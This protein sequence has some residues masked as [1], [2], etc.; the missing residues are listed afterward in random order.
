MKMSESIKNQPEKP[1]KSQRKKEVHDLQKIGETLVSLSNSLLAQI[2]LPNYLLESIYHAQTLKSHEAIRRQLQYIGKLMREVDI[3]PI[4]AALKKIQFRHQEDAAQ[5][6]LIEEWREKL[7]SKGDEALQE[8]VEIQPLTNRQ[9]LR[10]LIRKAQ[11]D[12]LHN[13][14]TGG[15]KSLFEHLRDLL[16]K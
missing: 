5:F 4:E 15:E 14:K 6:H 12:R 13:K 11:F 7:I 10:Q 2:P 3:V 8:L 9:V 1:S 16:K